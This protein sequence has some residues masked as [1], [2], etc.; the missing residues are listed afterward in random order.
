LISVTELI[1]NKHV[2]VENNRI[3][4]QITAYKPR[5]EGNFKKTTEEMI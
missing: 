2:T 5:G 4:R 3:P 1:G